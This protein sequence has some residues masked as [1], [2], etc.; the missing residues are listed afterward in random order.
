METQM[1]HNIGFCLG[2]FSQPGDK[3]KAGES[4]K[5]NFDIK[6]KNRHILTKKNLEVARFRLC[7]PIGHQN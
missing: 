4:N 7:V 6:K 1:F 3:K 5:G 2:E